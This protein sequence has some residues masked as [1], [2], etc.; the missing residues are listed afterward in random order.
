MTVSE[1]KE[2]QGNDIKRSLDEL[3]GAR[4]WL[5]AEEN[6]ECC[7]R[8]FFQFII[9]F[10]SFLKQTTSTTRRRLSLTLTHAHI[11]S[12]PHLRIG[13]G[14]EGLATRAIDMRFHFFAFPI[15]IPVSSSSSS[16][17]CGAMT[18]TGGGEAET[19]LLP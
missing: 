17:S 5:H 3:L 10:V 14:A 18:F 12:L 11:S 13:G 15:I 7:R 1:K 2:H 19:V 6:C 4:T 9:I 8:S 16:S